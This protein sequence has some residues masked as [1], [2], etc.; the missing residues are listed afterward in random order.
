M[1]SDDTYVQG[2]DDKDPEEVVEEFASGIDD[3]EKG[4]VQGLEMD[5]S[6]SSSGPTLSGAFALLCLG[7]I[8]CLLPS[9]FY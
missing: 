2:F 7:T 3:I 5:Q 4:K 1:D 9:I 6:L 8:V